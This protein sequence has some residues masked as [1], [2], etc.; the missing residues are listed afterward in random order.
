MATTDM[1]RLPGLDEAARALLFQAARTANAFSDE[2]V[3]D[4]ELREVWELA[5]WAPTSANTQPLRVTFVRT[6]E[7]KARLVRHLSEGN[8]AKTEQAPVAAV[9]AADLDFHDKLHLTFPSRPELRD[10]YLDPEARERSARY[11]ATLQAGYFILA[12]RAVG[13]AA[14]P[15][16]GYDAA[17]IDEEFFDGTA[18]RTVLVVNIGHPGEQPWFDR[19]PR[20][21]AGDVLSWA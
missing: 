20:L 4:D 7:G 14:G 17:G 16:L 21:D 13:L 3:G 15:M 12:V 5:R 10:R 2:P 19:L 1:T 18:L 6:P 11:N 9:L 8:R